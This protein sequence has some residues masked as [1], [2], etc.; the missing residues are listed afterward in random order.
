MWV[1]ALEAECNPMAMKRSRI[2]TW[3]VFVFLISRYV[4]ALESVPRVPVRN[5]WLSHLHRLLSPL[6]KVACSPLITSR[7]MPGPSSLYKRHSSALRAQD[8]IHISDV[9]TA[10]QLIT[11]WG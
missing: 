2:S 5:L 11:N 3:V 1:L 8:H 9:L 4:C 10:S 6:S 7:E